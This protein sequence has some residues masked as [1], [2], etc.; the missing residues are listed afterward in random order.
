M[1]KI[2]FASSLALFLASD[3][4]SAVIYQNLYSTPLYTPYTCTSVS[5]SNCDVTG[6]CNAYMK[7][8]NYGAISMVKSSMPSPYNSYSD[9]IYL[10]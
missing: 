3:S 2:L 1:K 7:S 10:A 6:D 4:F 5:S 9:S 8:N